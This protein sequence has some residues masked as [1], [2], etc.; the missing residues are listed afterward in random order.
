MERAFIRLP[1]QI[2]SLEEVLPN[3][4]KLQKIVNYFDVPVSYFT[5][6]D[7]PTDIENIKTPKELKKLLKNEELTLNDRLLSETGKEKLLKIIEAAFLEAN[8]M[9]KRKK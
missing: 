9:N 1:F 3:C 2:G 7:Q 6:N 5:N 8:E 4:K